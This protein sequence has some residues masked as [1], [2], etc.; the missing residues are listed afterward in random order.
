[1]AAAGAAG[2][3]LLTVLGGLGLVS[4]GGA[5]TA[6]SRP[7]DSR[8]LPVGG[9]IP[10]HRPRPPGPDLVAYRSTGHGRAVPAASGHGR[11]V[12]F[13]ISAQRVW[14][15]HRDGS[16]AATYLASG[17]VDHN[18]HP[19]HY[20]VYS[21]S[22]WATGIDDSGVMQYFVRFAHGQNAAIGFHSIPT[23]DGHPLQTRG[24]L[25]TPQSHGCIRQAKPDA[26]RLWH[27]A[28]IGT[29]V[30]VVA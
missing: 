26:I 21:R 5:A 24:Q 11:R 14:L 15:V 6:A 17:S 28:A 9:S 7:H 3:T 30:V 27:F 29:R 2:I 22:P 4:S 8:G 16:V 23:K 12:V 18:L 20:R 10:V 13:D 25:G 1:M 19:G